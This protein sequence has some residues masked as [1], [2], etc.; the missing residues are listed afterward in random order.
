MLKRIEHSSVGERHGRL[1]MNVGNVSIGFG[2][3]IESD[4]V[5]RLL[6]CVRPELCAAKADVHLH[7]RKIRVEGIGVPSFDGAIRMI[8]A[9][10]SAPAIAP[11]AVALMLVED[12][13]PTSQHLVPSNR[14]PRKYSPAGIPISATSPYLSKRSLNKPLWVDPRRF[15]LLTS[16]MR[17]RRATNCAKGPF[18]A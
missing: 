16:S 5:L 13:P 4:P 15:E 3:V 1:D 10:A 18:A 14:N 11:S 9:P 7:P 8:A 2:R 12:P 17:T 6:G